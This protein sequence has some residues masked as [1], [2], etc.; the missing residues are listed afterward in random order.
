MLESMIYEENPP[1][2][3]QLTAELT[4]LNK[5]INALS[6]TFEKEYPL[7]KNSNR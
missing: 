3:D 7:P 5:K 4:I 6:W 1:S 2:F